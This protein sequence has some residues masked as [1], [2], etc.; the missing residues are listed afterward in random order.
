MKQLHD[1]D[2]GLAWTVPMLPN[3]SIHIQV[4]ACVCDCMDALT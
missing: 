2:E 4:C 3:G 1:T